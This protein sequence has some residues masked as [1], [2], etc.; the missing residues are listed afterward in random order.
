MVAAMVDGSRRQRQS[1]APPPPRRGPGH[2]RGARRCHLWASPPPTPRPLCARGAGPPPPRRSRGRCGTVGRGGRQQGR[3]RI[4]PRRTSCP[5]GP[6]RPC[7]RWALSSP[8]SLWPPPALEPPHPRRGWDAA[9]DAPPDAALGLGGLPP[10]GDHGGTGGPGRRS[11]PAQ[12]A[13]PDPAAGRR[14]RYL[15]RRRR[16]R[17]RVVHR[18]VVV[19][20]LRSRPPRRPC[21]D[22]GGACW[23]PVRAGEVSPSLVVPLPP[24]PSPSSCL[25]PCSYLFPI[26]L[27]RST[28]SAPPTDGFFLCSGSPPADPALGG[29]DATA[30][31]PPR[32]V[33][34][35]TECSTAPSGGL[36][37]APPALLLLLTTAGGTCGALTP[38]LAPR[39]VARAAMTVE[40][41][42][43][44]ARDAG[45][46]RG[47]GAILSTTSQRSTL[48]SSLNGCIACS[49]PRQGTP[50]PSPAAL[51]CGASGWGRRWSGPRRG[52][53]GGWGGGCR[54]RLHRRGRRAGR[55]LARGPARWPRQPPLPPPRFPP[56][57]PIA[58]CWWPTASGA[59]RR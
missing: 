27:P 43:G 59:P 41:V 15:Q 36:P 58:S 14:R 45:G 37:A 31:P 23:I 48:M 39:S 5:C 56:P 30:R 19:L 25:S 16:C 42:R 35:S 28:T 33:S 22:A 29:P 11:P 17:R 10:D 21:P 18:V 24:S 54:S 20:L 53:G 55:G 47:P 51:G 40:R 49:L 8:G 34:S 4:H 50:P 9:A 7:P 38:A 6:C 32:S 2:R 3:R 12:A 52:G 26:A 1:P 13:S 44:R 46:T 57:A